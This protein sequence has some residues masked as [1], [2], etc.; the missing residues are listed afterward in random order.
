MYVDLILTDT[1]SREHS[2]RVEGSMTKR[3]IALVCAI[4]GLVTVEGFLAIN[5][6][7][8]SST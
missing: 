4:A 1:W 6:I 3:R 8:V 5:A 2:T 7:A